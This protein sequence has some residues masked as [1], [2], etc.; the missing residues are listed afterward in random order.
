[1]KLACA[2][3]SLLITILTLIVTCPR[4]EVECDAAGHFISSMHTESQGGPKASK[5]GSEEEAC[6]VMLGGTV[7][8]DGR[9]HL[10]L[11]NRDKPLGSN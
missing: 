4:N 5:A 10:Q 9:E 2:R 8:A 6:F 11:C 7:Q 3:E 1:M